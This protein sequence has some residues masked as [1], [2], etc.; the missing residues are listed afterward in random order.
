MRAVATA[1]AGVIGARTRQQ[2][3][4]VLEAACRKVLSFDAFFILGYDEAT[5]SFQGFG[6]TDAG[7]ESPPSRVDARTTPGERVIRE[8]RTLVTHRADDPAAAGAALTGT[9]RRSQSVIRTPILH[10]DQVLGIFS[11]QSYQPDL[12]TPADVEVVEAIAALAATALGNIRLLEERGAAERALR[13]AERDAQDMAS[14]MRAVAYAAAG[15]IGARSLSALHTVIRDACRKVVPFDAFTFALYNSVEHTLSYLEGYD[16]GIFVPAETISAKAVPSERVL[17]ERKSLLTLT[18]HDPA[19]R[20]AHLMGTKR[21]SESVIRTPVMSDD[22]VLA[23]IAM[24]SYTP[25]LYT[26]RDVEL[27]EAIASLAATALLNI[28]LSE[29]R[30]EAQAALQAAYSELERRVVERTTELARANEALRRANDEA[31][32]AREAAESANRAKSDFLSRMSHELRTPMNSILGF[33]QLLARR[34]LPSDQR[35]AIEHIL[36]AG[37]H[38][39]VLINEVLDLS[40]IETNRQELSVEPVHLDTELREAINLIR[41]LAVQSRCVIADDPAVDA[42]IDDALWVNADRQRLAQVLLNLLSNAVKYNRPSGR[43]WITCDAPVPGRVRVGVHDTGPGIPAHRMSELFVPFARLGAE[44][45]GVV[46][47]GLGLALSQRLVEAMGGALSAESAWGEGST[48]WLELIRSSGAVTR[49]QRSIVPSSTEAASAIPA[50]ILCIED[51]VD[52]LS[53]IEAVLGLRPGITMMSAVQGRIGL[54]LAFQ[55]EPDLLLLDMNLP[56]LPGIEVLRRLRADRRTHGMPVIVIS[57]DANPDS[58]KTLMH[59]GARAYITKP[60]DVEEF[61]RAVDEAL[62]SQR[63]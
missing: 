50:S 47:T 20:G 3:R 8:R 5:H 16:A 18:A 59:A 27:V 38:L 19:A 51:N 28:R 13:M 42:A 60:I 46:G 44:E 10:G 62:A 7:V 63:D 49:A 52:N 55:H 9:L 29:D 12:Y 45:S 41:P 11:V 21:R 4:A 17:R 35:R 58:I 14:R 54:D 53:L 15:V 23:I 61:L 1:A 6:G 26:Q 39:L 30:R 31:E 22:A 48:F 43:V 32:Q 56:D 37:Q 57:A 33:G 40:R 34:D 36:K 25:N 24:H 2:L